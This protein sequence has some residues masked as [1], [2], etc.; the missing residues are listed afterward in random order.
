MSR[1]VAQYPAEYWTDDVTVGRVC[2]D[3]SDVESAVQYFGSVG[4]TRFIAKTNFS[5]AGRGAK[6][7]D[8][9]SEVQG[10][11][12][13]ALRHQSVVVEPCF[14]RVVD[15][16]NNWMYRQIERV[17]TIGDLKPITRPVLG[18][19][20]GAMHSGLDKDLFDSFTV[21]A[22]SQRMRRLG[23]QVAD[24]VGKSLQ[25]VGYTGPQV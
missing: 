23:T 3:W 6:R 11:L 9:L 5:T 24:V 13:R 22:K 19:S 1:I 15:F 18:S 12:E 25:A 17:L 2:T 10:W 16:S 20:F 7:F 14:D 21:M 4:H 8:D